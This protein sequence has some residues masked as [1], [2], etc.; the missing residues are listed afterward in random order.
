[1]HFLPPLVHIQCHIQRFLQDSHL[2][3]AVFILRSF[4]HFIL[5]AEVSCRGASSTKKK[6]RRRRKFMIPLLWAG[7]FEWRL[8]LKVNWMLWKWPP[9]LYPIS[10]CQIPGIVLTNDCY[11]YVSAT[12]TSTCCKIWNTWNLGSFRLP[13]SS[14]PSKSSAVT[15]PSFS[16]STQQSSSI[17]PHTVWLNHRHHYIHQ[18]FHDWLLV[19]VFREEQQ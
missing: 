5:H 18:S 7:W 13:T 19:S 8:A 3:L 2:S 16:L 12:F 15:F 17:S 11:A 9:F 4:L 14:L 1:M 6:R 10:G